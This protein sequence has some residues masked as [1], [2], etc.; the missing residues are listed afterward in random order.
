MP[1][2]FCYNILGRGDFMDMKLERVNKTAYRVVTDDGIEIFMDSHRPE[3]EKALGGTPM[4][5]T[6]ASLMG[7]TSMVVNA[8]LRKMRIEKYT[9]SMK[10]EAK[11]ED[12]VPGKF[13]YIKLFYIF[14]GKDLNK[15]KIEKAV[16]KSHEKYCPVA[17]MLKQALKID[18]E[19]KYE[20]E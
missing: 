16:S 8:I 15:E 7:C 18:Y 20:E 19:I 9:Y 1:L 6:L 4:E 11:N 12:E 14:K 13:I 17:G 3:S 2:F 10:A 5:L